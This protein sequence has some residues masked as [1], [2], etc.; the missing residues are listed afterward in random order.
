M[1][2]FAA[3]YK[4]QGQKI[5]IYLENGSARTLIGKK[6][7]VSPEEGWIGKSAVFSNNSVYWTDGTGKYY[8]AG[9]SSISKDVRI[10]EKWK[11]VKTPP[12][13]IKEVCKWES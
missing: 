1:A 8:S 6:K 9:L 13:Y 5:R 12:Y 11:P 2:F 4:I 7:T 3:H 10:P